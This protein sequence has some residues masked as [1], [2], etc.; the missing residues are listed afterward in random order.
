MKVGL[1]SGL[2]AIAVTAAA[3]QAQAL[4][5]SPEV[6]SLS[7]THLA[8][9][10][11]SQTFETL[12]LAGGVTRLPAS[13]YKTAGVYFITNNKEQ[14]FSPAG[15]GNEFGDP[16]DTT[17]ARYGF[18]V[19]SCASG[20]FNKSCPYNDKIYDKC[21][22]ATYKYNPSQCAAPKKLSSD[23]CGGKYKCY[24]DPATYPYASCV[25]P[26]IKGAACTDDSGTR[27]QTC[28]CPTSVP[29]P[30][31]CQ[32]YYPSPCGSVCR[33][34]YADNCRNR[35]S[36]Q[37]PY[38]CE[39]YW[40]DCGSKCERAYTDN[41]R[42][43]NAVPTPYGCK[44]AW[45]D[46]ASKCQ[47]AYPDN[48]HNRGSVN[49]PYGC[50]SAWGDCASKCQVAYADNCR[51]RS[52]V[53]APYGCEKYWSDCSSK[54]E[55]A[56]PDN[57]R[58][59]SAVSAPYGCKQVWGDCTSKCQIAYPDNC[60]N[61]N[62][63]ST[64]YGCA[65]TWSDCPSKCEIAYGD[66]CHNRTAVTIPANAVC[67]AYYNDCSLKCSAW[68]CKS[69][70][71]QS[72]NSCVVAAKCSDGGY[73]DKTNGHTCTTVSYKG[74]TCYGQCKNT[75]TINEV[76]PD[77]EAC[78]G[79]PYTTAYYK[80]PGNNTSLFF[81]YGYCSGSRR[82][83]ELNQSKALLNGEIQLSVSNIYIND[84]EYR[85]CTIQNATYFNCFGGECTIQ[86][87]ATDTIRSYDIIYVE[88]SQ[89]DACPRF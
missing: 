71:M 27:Y 5:V 35:A 33:V 13:A 6:N 50:Q 69:G 14:N 88:K 10:N 66:N 26:Q 42:N 63:T 18:T 38:G 47:I 11:Q 89:A 46:C 31:G 30:Y 12:S 37:T 41:C 40:G 58:N 51:N 55:R 49:A 57:C 17:C 78:S 43:R 65:K 54:C 1:L 76:M 79:G 52:S 39:K 82:V 85:F 25:A 60:H 15:M 45:G 83:M 20:L 48:C 67:S 24:C 70:Y 80:E 75:I 9:L 64:V 2:S 8:K 23:T 22:D 44:Q 72:G 4:T 34:A 19:K 74:L 61:R 28:T 62:S 59:R 36:A 56:Y 86:V 3:V 81:R 16:T 73:L 84:K 87:Q 68:T 7:Y 53:P 32:T 77:A 21:C 29:T